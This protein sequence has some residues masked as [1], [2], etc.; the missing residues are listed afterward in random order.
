MK[1]TI[2]YI[3][4]VCTIFMSLSN[5]GYAYDVT[6]YAPDGRTL[7]IDSAETKDYQRVGW[8]TAPPVMM[9]APDGRSMYVAGTEVELY[10][11]VGWYTEP[12]ATMYALDGRT[13]V[14]NKNEVEA[15]KN[16]GWFTEPQITM[17]AP[18]GRTLVINQSEVE[19][20]KNVGWYTEYPVMMYAGDGRTMYVNGSEVELYKSVGWYTE[21]PVTMYAPDGRTMYVIQSEVELYKSVGWYDYPL[22]TVYA[23][24]GR[25]M[26]INA[27]EAEAYRNV[28][29]YT[30]RRDAVAASLPNHNIKLF[31]VGFHMN[32]ADGVEPRI[33]LRNDSGKTIKYIYFTTT[34]YNAVN[35]KVYCS[36][37]RDSTRELY[38]TG[39]IAPHSTWYAESGSMLYANGSSHLLYE[40]GG[41]GQIYWH[42]SSAP[43]DFSA[44]AEQRY[45]YLTQDDYKYVYDKY[46]W[47]PEWY[48]SDTDYL[49]I[50]K[51][52]VEY[53]D[54]SKETIYNPPVWTDAFRNAGL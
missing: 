54:G 18:D 21:P 45:R 42:D 46:F 7:V 11:G 41:N 38:I 2:T 13:L 15:Y 32:T 39:P 43:Y 51:I 48:N 16:V 49:V 1:K 9:Y 44:S 36:I 19:A 47:D 30:S 24:D 34:P 12:V 4:L 3:L 20:Y 23:S 29:W 25:T 50:S 22:M 8:Y 31:E 35:D 14:I 5:V 33:S 10:K 52:Y 40:H 28:G 27:N 26:M 6:M 37:H 17:Y 53:T